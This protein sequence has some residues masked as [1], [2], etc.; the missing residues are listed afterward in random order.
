[1]TGERRLRQA[2]VADCKEF[3]LGSQETV[4]AAEDKGFFSTILA[5][6]NNHWVVRT[7][8]E[9]WWATITQIIARQDRLSKLTF[10]RVFLYPLPL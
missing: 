4:C 3:C 5:A 10:Q 8:A 1:M 9:E 2:R 6:Y 7:R